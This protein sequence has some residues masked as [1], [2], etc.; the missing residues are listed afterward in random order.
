MSV[1]FDRDKLI[2]MRHI[3]GAHNCSKGA[4]AFFKRHG[5]SW[6]D[7]IHDGGLKAGVLLD[8]GDPMALDVV[9]YAHGQR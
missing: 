8:T 1:E 5:I 4:R 6:R 7:F 9:R 2:T 3:R